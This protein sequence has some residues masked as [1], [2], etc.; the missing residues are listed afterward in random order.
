MM[1]SGTVK[2]FDAE[3]GFGFIKPDDGSRDV[4]LHVSELRPIGMGEVDPG[5]RLNFEIEAGDKGPRA[6]NVAVG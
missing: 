2:K 1:A 5:T 6:V 3:R 4:F